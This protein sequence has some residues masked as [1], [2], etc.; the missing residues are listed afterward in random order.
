MRGL[1]IV[2]DIG[3]LR[4]QDRAAWEVLACG[5]KRFYVRAPITAASGAVSR[6]RQLC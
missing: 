1:A 2:I 4:S 3:P 5:Y 6:D